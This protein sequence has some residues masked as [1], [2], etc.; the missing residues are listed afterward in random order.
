MSSPVRVRRVYD[1]P[2]AE[3]GRR[4]LVDRLWPRGLRKDAAALDDWLRDVAP[5]SELR[6]WYG[7]EPARFAEFRR[8]YIAELS[9]P[10]QRAALGK[11]RGFAAEGPLTLLTATKDTGYSQAAVLADLLNAGQAAEEEQ[12]GDRACWAHLVCPDCGAV[13]SEGHAPGCQAGSS[14]RSIS[15]PAASSATAGNASVGA[16]N[17]PGG[18]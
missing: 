17:S 5:S 6:T 15:G 14:G 2:T 16:E 8:R 11:L 7:H 13:V 3:D 9:W 1:D 12:G 18:G 10:G 4:V